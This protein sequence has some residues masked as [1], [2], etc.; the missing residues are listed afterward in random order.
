MVLNL[1][2]SP[3]TRGLCVLSMMA[4]A[5]VTAQGTATVPL[6]PG[7]SSSSVVMLDST[8][9]VSQRIQIGL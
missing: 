3:Q 4:C 2:D 7:L 1:A 5:R 9:V 6:E 8:P